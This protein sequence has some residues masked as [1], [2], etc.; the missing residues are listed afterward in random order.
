MDS[1]YTK[2]IRH[3]DYARRSLPLTLQATVQ[4]CSTSTE[5]CAKAG[6]SPKCIANL[7]SLDVNLVPLDADLMSL[8]V[9]LATRGERTRRAR[10]WMPDSRLREAR[11]RSSNARFASRE[12]RLAMLFGLTCT[13]HK[14]ATAHVGPCGRPGQYMESQCHASGDE[15]R[16]ATDPMVEM[17]VGVARMDFESLGASSQV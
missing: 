12:S 11:F 2:C 15:R 16:S 14:P 13:F 7:P 9:H 5:Q 6:V 17:D 8:H 4:F 1:L 3:W 10:L